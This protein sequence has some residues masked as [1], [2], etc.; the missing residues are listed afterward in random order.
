MFLIDGDTRTSI[1]SIVIGYGW[2]GVTKDAACLLACLPACLHDS[3]P[4]N[5]YSTCG[6]CSTITQHML[7]KIG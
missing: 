2:V 5:C 3:L 1:K 4:C 6:T 7:C